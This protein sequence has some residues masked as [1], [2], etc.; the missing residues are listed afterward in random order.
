MYFGI[1]IHRLYIVEY[2]HNRHEK[3]LINVYIFL[4]S[5][6]I[7]LRYLWINEEI[8]CVEIVVE[9]IQTLILWV[10]ICKNFFEVIYFNGVANCWNT[11]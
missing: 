6:N 9:K 5:L 11:K 8:Y 1:E 3:L 7:L 2:V 10:P 4:I